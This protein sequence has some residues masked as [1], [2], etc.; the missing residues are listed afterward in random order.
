M[1]KDLLQELVAIPGPSGD[2]GR[3]T[4]RLRDELAPLVDDISIDKMG[5]LI[6]RREGTDPSRSLLL[7]AH[8]DE[9]SLVVRKI[10]EFVWFDVVGWIDP[11]CLM[12]TPVTVLTEYGE[13]PG[14]VCS[15]SAH[16]PTRSD[17]GELWI[18]VGERLAE[19]AVGD[20]V[21][22][23]ANA[24]W[25]GE[26]VLASKAIDDR[27]GCAELVEIARRLPGR[28]RHTTYFAAAVQEEVGSFGAKFV[29]EKLHPDWA[30]ALDTTGARDARVDRYR[31]VAI[32]SG[33]V[34]RRF[35]MAQPTSL[36]PAMLLFPSKHLNKLLLEAAGELSLPINQDVFRHT[37][38]D[39][40]LVQLY[41][42]ETEC[43]NLLVPRR[44]A[45]SPIEVVN[46]QDAEASVEI[47]LRMMERL[48]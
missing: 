40:T 38:T 36:Y 24:R 39:A 22:F 20:P 32:G 10:D 13:V 26:G 17:G 31:E 48:D 45:H 37:F 12:G 21:V 46:L 15:T 1:L 7:I 19:V 47:I 35:Q 8:S 34:V 28:P 25:L 14:V 43:A 16:S 18:D 9:V 5:N 44:Y 23:A 30:V 29:A 41:S 33:P 3:V 4:Q 6:A 27:V 42:P 2:E 11:A